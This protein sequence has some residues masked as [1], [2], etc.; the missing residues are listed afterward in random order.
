MNQWSL[1]TALLFMEDLTII[2]QEKV[3]S[4]ERHQVSVRSHWITLNQLS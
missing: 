3:S 1:I 2:S 4:K